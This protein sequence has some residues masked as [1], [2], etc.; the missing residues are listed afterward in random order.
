MVLADWA[1]LAPCLA[2]KLQVQWWMM[3]VV[4]LL[5]WE[6]L[7]VHLRILQVDLVPIW[8]ARELLATPMALL[9]SFQS[10]D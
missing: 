1:H 6:Q 10:Q 8:L 3:V 9:V 5:A 7:R 4:D 2:A